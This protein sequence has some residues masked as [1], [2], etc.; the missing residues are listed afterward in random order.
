[1]SMSG[2]PRLKTVLNAS[3]NRKN[4]MAH[5]RGA[6]GALGTVLNPIGFEARAAVI[7][8]NKCDW[9]DETSKTYGRYRCRKNATESFHS[10]TGLILSTFNATE[11]N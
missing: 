8:Q 7:F 2:Y 1:M 5:V 4:A 9:V 3:S 10:A 11:L 6:T